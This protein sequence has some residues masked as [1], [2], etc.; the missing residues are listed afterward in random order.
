MQ[1]V[2]ACC[3][4]TFENMVPVW[5]FSFQ[6]WNH[7]VSHDVFLTTLNIWCQSFPIENAGLG[8]TQI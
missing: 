4:V 2:V 8:K 5:V 7:L 6:K 1:G 3:Q